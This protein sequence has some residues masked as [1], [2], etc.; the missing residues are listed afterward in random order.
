[1]VADEI[2]GRLLFQLLHLCTQRGLEPV[3]H[4]AVL[5]RQYEAPRIRGPLNLEARRSAGFDEAELRLLEAQS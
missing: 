5:A 3:A 4:Y 2:E 1:M